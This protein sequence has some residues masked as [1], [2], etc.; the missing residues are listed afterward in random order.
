LPAGSYV[1]QA[2]FVA[3]GYLIHAEDSIDIPEGENG[4]EL[5][6]VIPKM[7]Q[8]QAQV[9]PPSRITLQFFDPGADATRHYTRSSD[10]AGLLTYFGMI[11]G[12]Y[13]VG[14]A[15]APDGMYISSIREGDSNVLKDG[16]DIHS[17]RNSQVNI[18]LEGPSPIV[19]GTVRDSGGRAAPGAIVT[20]LPDDRSQ[21]QEYV[22]ATANGNGEFRLQASP[23]SYHLYGWLEMEGSAYR[24]SEFMRQYD[25][26]GTPILLEKGS[27]T[28]IDLKSLLQL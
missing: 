23:G 3:A 25:D 28:A 26:E 17:G 12:H 4:K 13:R 21:Q 11:E 16:I 9:T 2:E 22:T 18:T 27:N 8:I 5:N 6:L 19:Y 1:I 14:G 7:G 20:L 24:N 10:S 15:T